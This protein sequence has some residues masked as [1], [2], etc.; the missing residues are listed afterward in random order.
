MLSISLFEAIFIGFNLDIMIM[1]FIIIIIKECP[2]M[3]V[4]ILYGEVIYAACL[5]LMKLKLIF[6]VGFVRL[7]IKSSFYL[8]FISFF[9]ISLVSF[10]L[11]IIRLISFLIAFLIAKFIG[12]GFYI[13]SSLVKALK[14][15]SI[16]HVVKSVERV[17]CQCF[18]LFVHSLYLQE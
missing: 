2:I 16:F 17:S 11:M 14:L 5:K 1:T 3:M 15:T 10:L 8:I 9:M 13:I 18:I 4:S 12:L 7:M 6:K